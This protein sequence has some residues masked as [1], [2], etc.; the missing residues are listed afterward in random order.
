[1]RHPGLEI[2][3][4]AWKAV[5]AQ[6]CS[7]VKRVLARKGASAGSTLCAVSFAQGRSGAAVERDLR[8]GAGAIRRADSE[9]SA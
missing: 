8:S 9:R 3:F 2:C 4:C 5:F 1:M 6:R 7:G